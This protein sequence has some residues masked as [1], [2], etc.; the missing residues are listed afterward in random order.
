MQKFLRSYY[1]LFGRGLLTKFMLMASVF[2]SVGAIYQ[3][4]VRVGEFLFYVLK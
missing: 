4:G 3:F 1:Q 2:I